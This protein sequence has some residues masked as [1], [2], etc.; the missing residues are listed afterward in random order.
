MIRCCSLDHICTFFNKHDSLTFSDS[1]YSTCVPPAPHSVLIR[2]SC[3]HLSST[4]ILTTVLR[5][6]L[7]WTQTTD[8]AEYWMEWQCCVMETGRTRR[9][10]QVRFAL[11]DPRLFVFLIG[12]YFFIVWTFMSIGYDDKVIA[13]IGEHRDF[14]SDWLRKT[15]LESNNSSDRLSTPFHLKLNCQCAHSNCHL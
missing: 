7:Q 5:L 12:F 1:I 13:E 15:R 8:G 2:S 6:V 4:S 11:H 9:L 10:H 14:L 3:M